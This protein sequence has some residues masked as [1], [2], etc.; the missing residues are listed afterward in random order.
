MKKNPL[1]IIYEFMFNVLFNFRYVKTTTATLWFIILN[2]RRCPRISHD[3]DAKN[4]I[5]VKSIHWILVIR[6]QQ[7]NFPPPPILSVNQHNCKRNYFWFVWLRWKP[8]FIH[9]WA[10]KLKKS[11]QQ[12][13]SNHSEAFYRLNQ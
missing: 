11:Y 4:F 1:Y 3:E 9:I 2:T 12:N 5:F 6:I 7:N 8:R 13:L 10:K